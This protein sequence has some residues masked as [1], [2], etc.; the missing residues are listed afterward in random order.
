MR[1]FDRWLIFV[2]FALAVAIVGAVFGEHYGLFSTALFILCSLAF[3]FTAMVMW[4]M[5]TSLG[6]ERLEIRNEPIDELRESLMREKT[7][8]TE[9][10][11][12]LET[13]YAAGKVDDADYDALRVS[14]ENRALEVIKRIKNE[15]A[16]WLKAAHEAAG[17]KA[18]GQSATATSTKPSTPTPT[19][20][21]T[22]SAVSPQREPAAD[23]RLFRDEIIEF[24]ELRCSGC[25]HMNPEDAR[26]CVSCGCPSK[27]AQ[28]A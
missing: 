28:V 4:R 16:K 15:D 19:P 22:P 27:E 18:G 8:L 26:F 3:A 25:G 10:L 5:L 20:T 7:L 14:A 17:V 13:D 6:D 12:E 23:A 24:V 21:P 2:E 1:S 11:K 9:G